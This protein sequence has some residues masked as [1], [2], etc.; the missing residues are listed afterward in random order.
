MAMNATRKAAVKYLS[1][2]LLFGSNGI[3]ASRIAMS[4]YEIVWTRTLIGGLLLAAI[5]LFSKEKKKFWHNKKDMGLI[6]LSGFAMGANWMF[7]YEAYTQ[8]GVSVATLLCYCGPVIVLALS[9]AMF[10]ERMSVAKIVG[11]S[12][13]LLGMVF[14]N[15]M[16]LLSSGFS[17]GLACG[18]LSA[19]MYALMVVSNK[20]ATSI[21]G[22]E[23]AMCQLFAAFF[24]VSVFIFIKQGA[25]ISFAVGDVWPILLLGL[26]NT[27]GGCYLYFSSIQQLRAQSVAILGYLEPL[28]ALFFSAIILS[29]RLTWLQLLGAVLIL[30]GAAFAELF[31]RK[32]PDK[33]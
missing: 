9:T 11:I 26:I 5:Y 21:T 31:R 17:W 30:G 19:V 15:G 33:T 13:A 24:I 1:A 10:R 29:E 32:A 2:L 18:L 8:I 7:L 20:K 23:N 16:S 25:A 3:V 28:S 4:S 6:M 27:G 22:L 14:L 12:A